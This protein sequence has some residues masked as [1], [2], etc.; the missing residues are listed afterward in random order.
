MLWQSRRGRTSFQVLQELYA[1]VFRKWPAARDKVRADVTDLLSWQPVV[2]DR[3]I[4]SGA[5]KIQD[6]FNLSF[7]D[8][9]IVAAAQ[10]ADCSY[11]LSED[12]QHEQ[13]FGAVQVINPFRKDP[14]SI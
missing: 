1:Q 8:C 6:R 14:N 5:W 3:E 13:K 2:I 10:S 9:L 12:L 11:L 4:I 7:W